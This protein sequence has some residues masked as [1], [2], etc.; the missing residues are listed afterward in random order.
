MKITLEQLELKATRLCGIIESLGAS[1]LLT[2]A[3]LEC[4]NLRKVLTRLV[5]DQPIPPNLAT[6]LQTP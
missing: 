4:S 1:D 6:W 3:S 5:D 2:T